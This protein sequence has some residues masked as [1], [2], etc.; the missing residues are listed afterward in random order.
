MAIR[1]TVLSPVLLASL[2]VRAACHWLALASLVSLGSA[3]GADEPLPLIP[4][5][6][7][8]PLPYGAPKAAAG[9]ADGL[10][11]TDAS[12]TVV[13]TLDGD[14]TSGP[15]SSTTFPAPQSFALWGQSLARDH[16]RIAIG[17]PLRVVNGLPVGSVNIADRDANGQWVV[18]AELL[19]P[20]PGSLFGSSVAV[21][22]D[23]LVVGSPNLDVSGVPSA[24]QVTVY[25]R[26]SGTWT[27]I[28]TLT[29]DVPAANE[30]FGSA[31]ALDGDR[32]V[33]GG[34]GS[35]RAGPASSGAL[36]IFER[37]RGRG[38]A[39][40]AWT[41]ILTSPSP[42]A[43]DQLGAS[44][45]VFGDVVIG[46]APSA[47]TTS[48]GA[49]AA[50]VASFDGLAWA[51]QRLLPLPSKPSQGFGFNVAAGAGRVIVGVFAVAGESATRT[52]E[53]RRSGNA[54][55]RTAEF[56]AKAPLTPYG[57]RV[58]SMAVGSSSQLAVFPVDLS[59]PSSLENNDCNGNYLADDCEIAAG[60][61]PDLDD[62]GVP[63]SCAIA[64]IAL[65]VAPF[66]VPGPSTPFFAHLAATDDHVAINPYFLETEGYA[67]DCPQW[68]TFVPGAELTSTFQ[69]PVTCASYAGGKPYAIR[70]GWAAIGG[71]MPGSI[72]TVSLFD[73]PAFGAPSFTS[74]YSAS[75]VMT[76]FGFTVAATDDELFV[77]RPVDAL[78]SY[79]IRHF[80]RDDAGDWSETSAPILLPDPAL[81]TGVAI[82]V[83]PVA[84][85]NAERWLA[86][87]DLLEAT[88]EFETGRVRLFRLM[89]D[90]TI[91]E[92]TELR[93]KDVA[94]AAGAFGV[95]LAL[96]GDRLFTT[97]SSTQAEIRRVLV[98][99]RTARGAWLP[100]ADL[101][102]AADG[103]FAKWSRDLSVR[104]NEVAVAR[105]AGGVQIF[106]RE[107]NGAWAEAATVRSPLD[108]WFVGGA[109][110]LLD[111][112]RLVAI[113]ARSG[114][115]GP[116]AEAWLLDPVTDCNGNRVDDS[117]EIAAG[118]EHDANLNG[119]PDSCERPGD[120]DGDGSVT[121]LD[122]GV[123]LGRFGQG[124][125]LGDLT[126]DGEV[127]AADIGALLGDWGR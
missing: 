33:I 19:G 77:P 49:G 102:V 3:A 44:V 86:V 8:I 75:S 1:R 45:D 67:A 37:A 104:G 96:V 43:G 17:A 73:V 27:P 127:D 61:A 11:L 52:A 99:R 12:S 95:H 40:F 105:A 118:T 16:G 81:S 106:R 78:G 42:L 124:P 120:L 103:V 79:P 36:W 66:V 70:D 92:D 112:G 85:S 54:W 4:P 89:P 48:A 56:D 6:G 76:W 87:S 32:V 51:A 72:G 65:E 94:G 34:T 111:D 88:P 125:G 39:P 50:V 47:N 22:G 46:G 108:A 10:V 71:L 9:D 126:D 31:L 83:G 114:S 55:S 110:A 18:A 84:G 30:R 122:L 57:P 117:A 23:T 74:S 68:G 53:F 13:F 25:E 62:D 97:W 38:S 5:S 26:R 116:L 21:D 24:G 15:W 98:Y 109:V 64:R 59:C 82:A 35:S 7:W 91:L 93:L 58:A 115:A 60:T 123:L 29:S 20:A 28:Q 113:G 100:E 119:V 2:F 107:A 121:A 101:E 69:L 80:R 41:A 14:P 90:D 63:D